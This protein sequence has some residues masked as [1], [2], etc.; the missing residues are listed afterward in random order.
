MACADGRD[1]TTPMERVSWGTS[2]AISDGSCVPRQAVTPAK[3]HSGVIG[4]TTVNACAGKE[5]LDGVGASSRGAGGFDGLA[6]REPNWSSS[7]P[8]GPQWVE[9]LPSSHHW[10]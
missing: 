5:G 8:Q 7:W 6:W 3:L 1:S 9:D 4:Q 10:L 2:E